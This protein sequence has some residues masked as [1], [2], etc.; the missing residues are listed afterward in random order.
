MAAKKLSS[1]DS[2]GSFLDIM[3][4]IKRGIIYKGRVQPSAIRSLDNNSPKNS[5]IHAKQDKQGP[6]NPDE[7]EP[8]KSENPPQVDDQSSGND[9]VM[10]DAEKLA[11]VAKKAHEVLYKTDTVFPFTLFPD[12]ITLEREKISIAKR[13]FFRVAKVTNI[14]VRDLLHIET[15]VG[16]FFGSIH[17]TSRFFSAEPLTVNYLSRSDATQLQRLLQG[18]IIA[19]ERGIDC[20]NIEKEQLIELLN[21]LGVGDTG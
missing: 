16:P 13:L 6:N 2:L 1:Y 9:E 11:E 8:S 20:T 18:Y 5:S 7:S 21:D 3:N 17:I 10:N 14:P 4:A 15:D 19:H 12:T